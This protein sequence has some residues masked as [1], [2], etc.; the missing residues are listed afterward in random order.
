LVNQMVPL[1]CGS[2]YPSST[3]FHPLE[4]ANSAHLWNCANASFQ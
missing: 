4:A 2:A 1:K 3:Q